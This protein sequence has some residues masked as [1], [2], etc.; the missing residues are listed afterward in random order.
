MSP[1][2]VAQDNPPDRGKASAT[3]LRAEWPVPEN[4]TLNGDVTS[5]TPTRSSSP[6]HAA[7]SPA[8]TRS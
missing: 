5:S 8:R 7:S 2:H 3:M 4:R 1:R 6:G